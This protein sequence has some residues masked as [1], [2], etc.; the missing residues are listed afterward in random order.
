MKFAITQDEADAMS[1]RMTEIINEEVER[2]LRA[3]TPRDYLAI[4]DS[5]HARIKE[6]NQEI[7]HLQNRINGK[8]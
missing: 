4:I 1:R 8:E 5:L 3:A 7:E 6:L 2:R